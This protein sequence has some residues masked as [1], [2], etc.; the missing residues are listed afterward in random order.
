MMRSDDDQLD[1]IDRIQRA[2]QA[3]RPDVDV[4]SIGVLSRA[5]RIARY[6]ERTRQQ[7]LAE[8]GTDAMTLDVL[9]TLRRSGLP[10]R[11]TAGQ[12]RSSALITS[13]AVTKR[14]D[15]LEAAGLV[16]RDNGGPDKRV[17]FVELT[18][19]GRALADD[20]LARLMEREAPLLTPLTPT[21]RDELE[22]LLHRW[23]LWL[24]QHHPD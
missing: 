9:A 20:T 19:A 7:A 6:L 18:D 17:V 14:V 15:K 23:L 16:R 21:Q 1:A 12:L 2:W 8:L 4:S 11:L 24:E 5:T 10:F 13:G 3:Q 22:T